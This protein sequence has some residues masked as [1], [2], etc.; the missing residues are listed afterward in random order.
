MPSTTMRPENIGRISPPRTLASKS[1][2][3]SNKPTVRMNFP[4]T[5]IWAAPTAG[6]G[7]VQCGI[8]RQAAQN[9]LEANYV[10]V[11]ITRL[12]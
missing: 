12:A 1:K 5:W 7:F 8:C 10:C 4:E 9:Y 6:Y 11:V 2:L 3:D